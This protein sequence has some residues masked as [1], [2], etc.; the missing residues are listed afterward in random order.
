MD[1]IQ[2]LGLVVDDVPGNA[3]CETSLIVTYMRL[4]G[5]Q[6]QRVQSLELLLVPFREIRVCTL[7]FGLDGVG[8]TLD[9][10]DF[11]AGE[12][13]LLALGD[14]AN[15]IGVALFV[16]VLSKSVPSNRLQA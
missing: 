2:T 15:S 10:L 1:M 14:G 6:G 16:G 9:R 13:G 7:G 3:A 12:G 8:V 11:R 4:G 5:A